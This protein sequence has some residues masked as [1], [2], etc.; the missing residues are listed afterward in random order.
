MR[1]ADHLVDDIEWSAQFAAPTVTP[2]Q[3]VPR[4]DSNLHRRHPS[5]T[6]MGSGRTHSDV[7]VD[8]AVALVGQL[9]VHGHSQA[10]V[11]PTRLGVPTVEEEEQMFAT[12][13]QARR[14]ALIALAVMVVG[15]SA[16]WTLAA[17]SP[18]YANA[19]GG[20]IGAHTGAAITAPSGV[21]AT[22]S[23]PR[24]RSTG[25]SAS[26]HGGASRQSRG[27]GLIDV[28]APLNS[29]QSQAT[30]GSLV[31]VNVPARTSGATD[32]AGGPLV[33]VSAP[34]SAGGSRQGAAGLQSILGKLSGL[35]SI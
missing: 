5:T 31:N 32:G 10:W 17:R 28:A 29:G 9:V 12:V 1:N 27:S 4:Q 33:N 22:A 24:G 30:G 23:A 8:R 15:L 11:L 20:T 21:S 3:W 34:L 18:A 6:F 26:I 13:A 16:A 14:T 19:C 35:A 7:G 25:V 2:H